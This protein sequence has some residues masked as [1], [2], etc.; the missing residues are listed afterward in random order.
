[1][2]FNLLMFCSISA[3]CSINS[4]TLCMLLRQHDF[5][6]SVCDNPTSVQTITLCLLR[7][8]PTSVLLKTLVR[9]TY[10]EKC[11]YRSNPPPFLCFVISLQ[12]FQWQYYLEIFRFCHCVYIGAVRF[13]LYCLTNMSCLG[14]FRVSQCNKDCYFRNLS[15]FLKLMFPRKSFYALYN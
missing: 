10:T 5:Y 12:V 8:R 4:P 15:K 11:H 1:M 6:F 7:T 13:I 9:W 2:Q 3:V 14:S